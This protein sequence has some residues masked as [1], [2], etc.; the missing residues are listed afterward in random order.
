MVAFAPLEWIWPPP[1][2]A[3][4]TFYSPLTGHCSSYPPCQ[5]RT[6]LPSPEYYKSLR[7]GM[8]PSTYRLCRQQSTLYSHQGSAPEGRLT[9]AGTHGHPCRLA[10]S[11]DTPHTQAAQSPCFSQWCPS[12]TGVSA[13]KAH[14]S[15]FLGLQ[16]QDC[17]TSMKPFFPAETLSNVSVLSSTT[18]F[19]ELPIMSGSLSCRKHLKAEVYLIPYLLYSECLAW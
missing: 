14:T 15:S 3:H 17:S 4:S 12:H 11:P 10:F 5:L 19:P 1:T 6:S 18:V 9:M 2:R 8:S 7:K 13:Q 16:F